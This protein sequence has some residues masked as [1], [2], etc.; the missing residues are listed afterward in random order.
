MKILLTGANGQLGNSIREISK[1][2]NAKIYAFSKNELDITNEKQIFT[3]VE[4]IKPNFIINAAAYTNVDNSENNPDQ[5]FSINQHGVRTVS[6][7]H[8]TL[9]TM[10]SV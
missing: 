3:V 9:P 7:T 1:R 6:Y 5:A 8:L 2:N 10:D 4:K